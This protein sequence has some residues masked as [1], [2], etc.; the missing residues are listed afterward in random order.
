MTDG[1]KNEIARNETPAEKLK[2]LE[3]EKKAAAL[4]FKLAK[5][6]AGEDV[7]L[8]EAEE[9]GGSVAAVDQNALISGLAQ[10]AKLN[11][12]GVEDTTPTNA[13]GG[14]G[15]KFKRHAGR[16]QNVKFDARG[17]PIEVDFKPE[18]WPPRGEK[19]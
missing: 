19:F 15:F 14:P 5:L 4:R 12:M 2:R 3:R 7:D 6:E 1:K 13:E 8:A 11:D 17:N 9:G 10:I 16:V 18:E